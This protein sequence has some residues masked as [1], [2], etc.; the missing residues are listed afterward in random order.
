MLIGYRWMATMMQI[1]KAGLIGWNQPMS[2]DLWYVTPP[3][4]TF[5]PLPHSLFILHS[6]TCKQAK[7]RRRRKNRRKANERDATN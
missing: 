4:A 2:L 5:H 1:L 6:N 7:G 3:S